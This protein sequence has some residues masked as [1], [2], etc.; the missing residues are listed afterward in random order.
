MSTVKDEA[1]KLRKNID[2]VYE[3][4]Q[5][6]EYDR[7]WDALQNYGA[8]EICKCQFYESWTNENFKPKY[9]LY[10][11][12]Q[13]F[14]NNS[15]GSLNRSTSIIDLREET[16]GV[17]VDWSLCDNFN[18]ILRYAKTVYLDVVDMTNAVYGWTFLSGASKLEYVKKVILPIKPIAFAN[19]GF[20]QSS[21]KE[22]R[23]EGHFQGDIGLIY[24]EWSLESLKSAL[25]ALMDYSGTD[26]EYAYTI[27][28]TSAYKTML[29]ADGANSPLGTTWAE[30]VTLK[31]W[32]LA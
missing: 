15:D 28:L 14:S 17:K 8:K 29:E 31:G 21:L 19:N 1:I 30:Y 23:F 25:T 26:N 32:N 20:A 2:A 12:T 10:A 7:F 11:S 3:A 9:T 16:L 22:I 13:T 27:T 5:K 24:G 6:A 18:Y 4:G